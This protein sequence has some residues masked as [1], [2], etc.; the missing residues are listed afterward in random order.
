MESQSTQSGEAPRRRRKRKRVVWGLVIAAAVAAGAV[1]FVLPAW[2]SSDSGRRL[3]L[4]RINRSVDGKVDA[5]TLSV[6]WFRGIRATDVTYADTAGD[7]SV[8]VEKITTRPK[9]GAM[10]RGDLALG[11]TVL[12]SPRVVL[13]V[14]GPPPKEESV[15]RTSPPESDDGA[16]LPLTA[17]DLEV[18]DG[19]AR[20]NLAS[21]LRMQ[22]VEF[23]NIASSVNLNPRGQR[24]TFDL[25]MAVAEDGAE[26]RVSAAGG[27][28]RPA[29]KWTLKGT[30]GDFK[31]NVDKLNLATLKPLFVLMGK[32]VAASGQL[33]ADADVLI[34]EGR[35]EKVV[36]KADL[37]DFSQTVAG[38]Q[39]VIA[40][41]VTVDVDI[42]T[43]DEVTQIKRFDVQSS[44][45]TIR[46]KGTGKDVDYDANA[47]L[48]KLQGVA[49]QFTNFGGYA[50]QGNAASKGRLTLDKGMWAVNGQG[51]VEKLIISKGDVTTPATSANLGFDVRK[52]R[53]A[54]VM[55]I[56][57]VKV[58]ADV[59]R[60]EVLNS[61][62]PAD[63]RR[64]ETRL[65]VSAD[66]DLRKL[67]PFVGLATRIPEGVTFA[68]RLTSE[69]A[70]TGKDGV[71]HVVTE[72]TNVAGL[73]ITSGQEEPF[74]Q[75]T[76]KVAV[77]LVAD[78]KQKEITVN[79]LLIEGV[80]GQS[81]IEVMKGRFNKNEKQ[82]KTSIAGE[83]EARYDL[84]AVS[85]MGAAFLPRGL[86]MEG[87]RTTS[88][89]FNSEYPTGADQFL[90]NLSGKTDFGFDK[91][92][93]FG[94]NVGPADLKLRAEHG[95]MTIDL[96]P[97][98]VNE[99]KTR[100]AGNLNFREAPMTV[101]MTAPTQLVEN[102][103]IN[104]EMSKYL[105]TYINPLFAN[106]V[107][108]TGVANFQCEK[109]A[110]PLDKSRLKEGLQIT[111]T[112]QLDNVQLGPRGLRGQVIPIPDLLTFRP[113]RFVLENGFLSYEN[114]EVLA[115]PYP[116]NFG[117]RI[118][119]DR[120]I[121]MDVTFPL[122]LAG[123]AVK[124]GDPSARVTTPI[125][126]T[127]DNPT[128]NLERLM[129][130][131]GR[132]LLEEQLKKTEEEYRK[133]LEKIFR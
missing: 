12:E 8:S 130:D 95:L 65:N 73:V 46:C 43:A 124:V 49:S 2:L 86:A 69:A 120:S 100:F 133:R 58:M 108:V 51:L 10:L 83:L 92:K 117:G 82:E 128:I 121:D 27:M 13:T 76:V 91:A 17:L 103:K 123:K 110:I 79:D 56:P 9:L 37:R 3:V 53:A 21:D 35:I 52:D 84:A 66:V 23:K 20:I 64:G 61:V 102:V 126:G 99:G 47:D 19:N 115:G 101:R 74:K 40:E 105:L 107:G 7:A 118:G 104:D 18:K 78:T 30:S 96:P 98:P 81:L 131:V 116:I 119:M 90:A 85:A 14:H 129:E 34:D 106:Q 57:S 93:Y 44:F 42:A 132:Q 22:T 59:G 67:Q 94:L 63:T 54:G 68:G 31:V 26:S 11:R 6:G 48:A 125:G 60:I 122:S 97:A 88:L 39:T 24:S 5:R 113:T 16:G 70:V 41:P 109:L 114:M 71:M 15:N 28:T 127:L 1:V 50:L 32:D 75:E 72:K 45:C 55:N 112:V 87:V 62:I 25:S 36:A 29:K 89:T 111:G 77:D 33:T 38:K 4:S 80:Q